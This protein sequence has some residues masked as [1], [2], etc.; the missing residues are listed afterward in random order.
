MSTGEQIKWYNLC[1]LL[2]LASG[3]GSSEGSL[4]EVTAGEKGGREVNRQSVGIVIILALLTLVG[5][6]LVSNLM[7]AKRSERDQSQVSTT[8]PKSP[9]KPQLSISPLPPIGYKP[10]QAEGQMH[11]DL[12]RAQAL[13]DEMAGAVA[14]NNWPN[15]QSL[16]AEFQRKTEHLPAPQ[17]HHPDISPVLQDFFDLYSVKLERALTEQNAQ[18]VS[19][20]LNQLYGIVGEQRARLGA[21]SVPLEFQRLRFLVREVKLW[22]ELGDEKMLRLRTVAL[23]D[24][25]SQDVRPLV[26]ARRSGAQ[27]NFDQLV[28]RLASAEQVHEL[29][30]L[31]PEFSKELEQIDNLFRRPSRPATPGGGPTKTADEEEE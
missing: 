30:A 7:G 13:I 12:V 3:T 19:L 23:R 10:S 17:L 29:T 2:V 15:A 26:V 25:W 28:Q 22:S 24:A 11:A 14:A 1:T 21:R 27:K 20:A 6:I 5:L 9:N 16:Y 4:L 8:Q 18:D 31:L